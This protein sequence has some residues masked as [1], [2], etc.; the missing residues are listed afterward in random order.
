MIKKI[1]PKTFFFTRELQTPQSQPLAFR[2]KKREE[3]KVAGDNFWMKLIKKNFLTL[4][5]RST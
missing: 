1:N 5:L 4:F 2:R 3:F